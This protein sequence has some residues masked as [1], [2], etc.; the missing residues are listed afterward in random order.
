MGE[1]LIFQFLE[2]KREGGRNESSRFW[3]EMRNKQKI[4]GWK[5]KYGN[6]SWD[7]PIGLE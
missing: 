3:E 2:Y 1:V 6:Y 4:K 7:R 5:K